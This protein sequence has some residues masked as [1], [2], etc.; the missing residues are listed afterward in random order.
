MAGSGQGVV[1]ARGVRD[2]DPQALVALAAVR[3]AAV[4]AFCEQVCDPSSTA[5]ATADAF[6]RFR[7]AVY[8]ASRIDTIDPEV[9]LLRRTRLAAAE[10][11]LP[12]PPAT[13]IRERMA[14]RRSS[15]C[16]NVPL[17]LA[18][19]ANK[20]LSNA[21]RE[22]LVRHLSR[23]SGCRTI[24]NRFREAE[25][26]Y[27]RA[28]PGSLPPAVA[29]AIV[30]ALT[31]AAPVTE[32]FTAM[33]AGGADMSGGAAEPPGNGR[34]P[35][36]EPALAHLP[37]DDPQADYGEQ[38]TGQSPALAAPEVAIPAE[39]PIFSDNLPDYDEPPLDANEHGG[40]DPGLTDVFSGLSPSP[41]GE[42]ATI[43]F[44]AG[45]ARRA[46]GALLRPGATRRR[47]ARRDPGH[48]HQRRGGFAARIVAPAVI[49]IAGVGAALAVAG[50]FNSKSHAP[51]RAAT[52]VATTAAPAA[53]AAQPPATPRR[54]HRRRHHRRVRAHHRAAR[55]RATAT[56]TVPAATT[57]TATTPAQ[58]VAANPP[59][60]T[61]TTT[62]R[63]PASAHVIGGPTSQ[64]P[65]Q[66]GAPSGT[67][68]AGYQPSSP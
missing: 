10:H 19:R 23:C 1:T 51:R 65:P 17:L 16:A 28:E 33:A 24:E 55:T 49:V 40:G 25:R 41:R 54:H 47:T 68:P 14:R 11:A 8:A 56:A 42:P 21:D 12:A 6:A 15:P 37:P 58:Q 38:P 45:A 39:E 7:S 59:A 52:V 57:P 5:V 67:G 36:H 31:S 22:R 64:A 63:P 48:R 4:L 43:A 34:A 18:A 29:A 13:G 20:D 44:A 46:R 66:T 27:R 62:S 35:Q 61:R 32:E 60:P 9:L 30:S 53:A 26:A 2:G 50:V 3:G